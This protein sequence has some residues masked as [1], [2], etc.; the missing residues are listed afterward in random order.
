MEGLQSKNVKSRM[1]KT[2]YL[3]LFYFN[4]TD[5]DR[6]VFLKWRDEGLREL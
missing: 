6:Q 2:Y 5:H 1:G 4:S 3:M